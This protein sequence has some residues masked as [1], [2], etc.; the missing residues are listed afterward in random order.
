MFEHEIPSG[1]QIVHEGRHH[2]H[3]IPARLSSSRVPLRLN[4]PKVRTVDQLGSESSRRSCLTA[5]QLI[6]QENLFPL[7][8]IGQTMPKKPSRRLCVAVSVL[9]ENSR[10]PFSVGHQTVNT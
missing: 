3:T 6:P 4:H 5:V 8:T 2:Y 7:P 9:A 10:S 1:D